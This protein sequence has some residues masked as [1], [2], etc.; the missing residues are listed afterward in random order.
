MWCLQ[1]SL[2]TELDM[3]KQNEDQLSHEVQHYKS[4]LSDTVRLPLVLCYSLFAKPPGNQ[5]S[6]V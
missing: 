6:I 4:V 2:Q 5:A 1:G 3:L